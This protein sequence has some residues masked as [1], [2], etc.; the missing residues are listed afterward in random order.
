MQV[1]TLIISY[2]LATTASNSSLHEMNS[3]AVAQARIHLH[4]ML[5]S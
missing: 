4:S 3:S 2:M 5:P 1:E